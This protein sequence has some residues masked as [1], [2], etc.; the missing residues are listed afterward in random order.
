MGGG[1]PPSPLE[2][3]EVCGPHACKHGGARPLRGTAR[4]AW[5]KQPPLFRLRGRAGRSRWGP[6]TTVL[7]STHTL[8]RECFALL[9][10][11]VFLSLPLLPPSRWISAGFVSLSSAV[12]RMPAALIVPRCLRGQ[13][14]VT[15]H[16]CGRAAAEGPVS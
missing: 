13:T 6:G 8:F 14:A 7:P 10:V 3:G 1:V 9:L 12:W 4:S 11:L 15:L 5:G 16:T 2:L